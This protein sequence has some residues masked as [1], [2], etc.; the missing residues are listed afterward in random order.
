[1]LTYRSFYTLPFTLSAL[2]LGLFEGEKGEAHMTEEEPNSNDR[3][4]ETEDEEMNIQERTDR[5]GFFLSDTFVFF[6]ISY[7]SSYTLNLSL[8]F[9][10]FLSIHCS[11]EISLEEV[12]QRD[13]IEQR[14]TAKWLV[15][16]K[17]WDRY[18]PFYILPF[19]LDLRERS[20][21][22]A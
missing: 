9:P 19:C 14:R 4:E 2:E 20:F 7:D 12:E 5:Y 16:F 8:S 13:R 18:V 3:S 21:L 15:M 22:R 11:R 1:M 10:L 6:L 17:N